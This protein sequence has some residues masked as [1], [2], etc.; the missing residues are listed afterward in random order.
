MTRWMA[1][2]TDTTLAVYLF[3]YRH[4]Y[5]D[6]FVE[7]ADFCVLTYHRMEAQLEGD[8]GNYFSRINHLYSDYTHSN[9]VNKVTT[10]ITR[11]CT[12]YVQHRLDRC[13]I[14]MTNS[15]PCLLGHNTGF[16]D[17]CTKPVRRDALKS[18]IDASAILIGCASF[19]RVILVLPIR[20]S[21]KIVTAT[22]PTSRAATF[23]KNVNRRLSW[24][25]TACPSIQPGLIRFLCPCRRQHSTLWF[26]SW[27]CLKLIRQRR[28]YLKLRHIWNN[29]RFLWLGNHHQTPLLK[30]TQLD[31]RPTMHI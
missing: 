7:V 19:I 23:R 16:M 9:P 28:E 3:H 27:M 17:P 29:H 2:I 13:L 14:T 26:Q 8:D 24:R 18:I 20:S 4:R 1:V 30:E 5:Y 22:E 11:R 12:I 15:K 31:V 6:P 10:R 25:E 21:I